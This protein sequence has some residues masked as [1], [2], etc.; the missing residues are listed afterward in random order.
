MQRSPIPRFFGKL[1]NLVSGKQL[2]IAR[3]QQIRELRCHTRCTCS[4]CLTLRRFLVRK[5]HVEDYIERMT[6]EMA[7][8]ELALRLVYE[9]VFDIISLRDVTDGS[10]L[11]RRLRNFGHHKRMLHLWA[12]ARC[13][14]FVMYPWISPPLHHCPI[15]ICCK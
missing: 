11:N 13:K 5:Y 7:Q 4:Q 3:I 10:W 1:E 15:T 6:P 2:T 14:P 9:V 12:K 8:E